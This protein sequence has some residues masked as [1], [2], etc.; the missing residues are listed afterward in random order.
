MT[1]RERFVLV[2]EPVAGF[3]G[4]RALRRALKVLLR[5]CGLKCVG[6]KRAEP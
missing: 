1:E 6:T 5:A 3:D 2:V 4:W